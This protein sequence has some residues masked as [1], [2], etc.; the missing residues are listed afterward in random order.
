MSRAFEISF[1]DAVLAGSNNP[2]LFGVAV[3][4]LSVGAGA[5]TAHPAENKKIKRTVSRAIDGFYYGVET[6]LLHTRFYLVSQCYVGGE[7]LPR[8]DIVLWSRFRFGS[9][10]KSTPIHRLTAVPA[11]FEWRDHAPIDPINE[12][13]LSTR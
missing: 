1:V 9:R 7:R 2:P 4:W 3:D 13:H 10:S 8:L 11:R 6:I 5:L 12:A